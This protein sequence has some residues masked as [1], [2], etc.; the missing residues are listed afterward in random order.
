MEAQE[1]PLEQTQ[2]HVTEGEERI[3]KQK[4][5]IERLKH[6]GAEHEMLPAAEEM[7]VQ[8]H[9]FQKQGEKHLE[10]EKQKEHR[11]RERER[12]RGNGGGR[13]SGWRGWEQ[14]RQRRIGG[15]RKIR[16]REQG[17]GEEKNLKVKG[18]RRR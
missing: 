8:M 5:L 16:C 12:E 4:A 1:T 13:F 11:E 3:A 17:Q 9:E 15:R 14:R 2:R 18:W 6:G 10:R 7:L